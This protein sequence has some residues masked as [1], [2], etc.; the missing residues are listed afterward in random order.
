MWTLGVFF[1]FLQAEDGIRV[2]VGSRGL[3]DVNKRQM[4][5][6]PQRSVVGRSDFADEVEGRGQRLGALFPLGLS[7]IHI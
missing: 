7:L 4:P 2:L 3:G 5:G 6:P 1:V